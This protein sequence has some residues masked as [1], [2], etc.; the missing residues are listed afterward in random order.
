MRSSKKAKQKQA[1]S[2]SRAALALR[3]WVRMTELAC[4]VSHHTQPD[5]K[6]ADAA[7]A[8]VVRRVLGSR[9]DL[10]ALAARAA[11]R[12][13]FKAAAGATLLRELT[14][15]DHEGRVLLDDLRA[16]AAMRDAFDAALKVGKA[17]VRVGPMV[18]PSWHGIVA[19]SNAWPFACPPASTKRY[20]AWVGRSEERRVGKECRSRWSPY[21]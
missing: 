8:T 9:D 10:R 21:H 20:F 5:S 16:L 7:G 19:E 14:M 4:D 12:D 13:E 6:L 2:E 15:R 3:L 17:V 18:G 11:E 1:P